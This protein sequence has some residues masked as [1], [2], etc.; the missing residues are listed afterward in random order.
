M[1]KAKSSIEMEMAKCL[2]VVGFGITFIGLL[3]HWLIVGSIFKDALEDGK[4]CQEQFQVPC[5]VVWVPEFEQE[6]GQ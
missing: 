2:S 5:K 1:R 4:V 3:A 6:K